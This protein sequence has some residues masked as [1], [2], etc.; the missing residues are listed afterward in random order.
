MRIG[1]QAAVGRPANRCSRVGC[2]SCCGQSRTLD[3]R[4][5]SPEANW[6]DR[7]VSFFD[8]T[9]SEP[10]VSQSHPVAENEPPPRTSTPAVRFAWLAEVLSREELSTYRSGAGRSSWRR[11]DPGGW[12]N[13]CRLVGIYRRASLATAMPMDEKPVSQAPAQSSARA[14]QRYQSAQGRER[15]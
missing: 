1:S 11:L 7:P 3:I 8:R 2:E 4:R 14:S 15:T 6:A 12:F 13:P 9:S 5:P 10:R